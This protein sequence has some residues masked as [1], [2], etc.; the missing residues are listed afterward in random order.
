M[1]ALL[2]QDYVQ[3]FPEK[4][5]AIKIAKQELLAA[6]HIDESLK[7]LQNTTHI[8]VG[9]S[10]AYG[11]EQ[12]RSIAGDIEFLCNQYISIHRQTYHQELIDLN[13]KY[14]DKR[15]MLF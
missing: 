4:V 9:S 8:I 11:F 2:Q 3:S 13:L 6:E 1:T 7:I 12:I 15:I 10:G 14:L 5:K